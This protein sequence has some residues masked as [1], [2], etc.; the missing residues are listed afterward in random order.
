M[1]E[2]GIVGRSAARFGRVKQGEAGEEE[3]GAVEWGVVGLGLAM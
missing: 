1:V 2:L 3:I